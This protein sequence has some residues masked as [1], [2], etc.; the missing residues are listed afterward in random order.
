[1]LQPHHNSRVP[2]G[3]LARET[4]FTVIDFETTGAV[5]GW[6]VEPWQIGMVVMRGGR[7]D[8]SV[9]FESLLRVAP[10]RPFNRHA[11]GRHALLRDELAHAATIGVLWDELNPWLIGRPL[12]AHNV[13]TERT[14][15]KKAAPLHKFGPWIDTL[16]IIRKLYPQHKSAVLDDLIREFGLLHRLKKICPRRAPHDALY[17]ACACAV[18]LEWLLA[19]NGWEQVTVKALMDLR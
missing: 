7:V 13:G 14:I 9:Q 5:A 4:V 3:Q 18:L 19:Q 15:L 16:R 1:M 10:G 17:D 8:T 12:V 2:D 6:P 11:P